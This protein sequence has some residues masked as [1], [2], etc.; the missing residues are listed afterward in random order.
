[1]NKLLY[2]HAYDAGILLDAFGSP[3]VDRQEMLELFA[4][5]IL[6]DMVNELPIVAGKQVT[7]SALKFG[8]K[9]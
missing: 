3:V 2:K 8:I 1:M 5:N 6:T 9:I 7:T 4:K